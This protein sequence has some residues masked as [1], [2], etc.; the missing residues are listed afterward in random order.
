MLTLQLDPLDEQ[1]LG[2]LAHQQGKPVN[3]LV[4]ELIQAYLEDIHDSAVA[5]QALDS[6]ARGESTTSSLQDV[7][8]RL[9]L[10]P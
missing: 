2:I 1:E 4:T 10:T 9:G 7:M 3:V 5:D 8:Q 6:L